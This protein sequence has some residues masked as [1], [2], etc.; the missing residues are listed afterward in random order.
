MPWAKKSVEGTLAF[1]FR[2]PRSWVGYRS[3]REPY[4]RR[5]GRDMAEVRDWMWLTWNGLCAHCRR[6]CEGQGQQELDHIVPRGKGGDDSLANLQFLC[7]DCHRKKH[8]Q[9]KWSKRA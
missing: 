5:F 4:I 1:G 9:V 6:K 7:R 8:V 3:N 2:D